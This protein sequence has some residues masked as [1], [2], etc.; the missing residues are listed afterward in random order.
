MV[1]LYNLEIKEEKYNDALKIINKVLE[2][3]NNL[4]FV[5]KDKAFV[6]LKLNKIDESKIYL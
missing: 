2:L 3:N 5:A 1:N 6:F 4:E